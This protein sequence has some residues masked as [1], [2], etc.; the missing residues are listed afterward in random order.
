MAFIHTDLP[1]PVEPA[2]NK[3]GV[4]AKSKLIISPIASLPI[5]VNNGGIP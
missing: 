3:C 4:F 2:T 1:L 5:V